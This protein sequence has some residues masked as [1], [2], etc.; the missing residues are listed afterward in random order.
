MRQLRKYTLKNILLLLQ[1]TNMYLRSVLYNLVYERVGHEGIVQFVVTPSSEADQ[2]DEN[3]LPELP[4][5]LEG[6]SRSSYNHLQRFRIMI[7]F[8][9]MRRR[10]LDEDRTS[11]S[12]AFT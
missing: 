2:I 11:G 10:S 12:S 4:L 9:F 1:V 8:R 7:D 5:I 6:Y 3:V